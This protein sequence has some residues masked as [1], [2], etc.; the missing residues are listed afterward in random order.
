[1]E[2]NVPSGGTASTITYSLKEGC[3][4]ANVTA[5]TDNTSMIIIGTVGSGKI[6]FTV[7]EN[8]TTEERTG[9]ITPSV[10]G[11]SCDSKQITI[12]QAAG[13]APTP[14]CGCGNLNLKPSSLE[15]AYNEK[16]EKNIT[17]TSGACISDITIN[18]LTNFTATL[19]SGVIKVS[20]KGENQTSAPY[21]ETLEV[22][23]KANGSTCEEKKT[24]SLKQNPSECQ[25]ATCICYL[26]SEATC[27]KV[28]AT[29]T[30]ATVTWSYSA[31]TW[32]TA[33]T[34]DVTS[35][36]TQ[37]S[38]SKEVSFAAA[39]C[40]NFS[41]TDKFTW[42]DHKG[43]DLSTSSC[44]NA[45]VEVTWTVN[46]TKPDECD[47][48]CEDLRLSD[49]SVSVNAGASTSV[50]Y[51]ADC[52]S[53][54]S[55]VASSAGITIDTGTT[56]TIKITGNTSGDYKITIE[57][58]KGEGDSNKCTNKEIPVKVNCGTVTINPKD[59]IGDSSGGTV[60]FS[61]TYAP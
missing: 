24:V 32:T 18:T 31:I 41:K 7:T 37:E 16:D 44:T 15:W 55:I 9:H 26:V 27:E 61:A 23:Y 57:F 8:T 39:T 58:N 56:G 50:T 47:C 60:N 17:L 11:N 6:N 34:C 25:G 3:E 51:S 54:T 35:S 38:E 4:N 21:E 45:D 52:V 20:P 46:Q 14:T 49:T 29:A 1:M 43:C 28:A 33:A 12:K 10:N 53:I 13:E 19:G 2:I 30:T 59:R 36:M 5:S 40:D 48:T 42:T 22:T